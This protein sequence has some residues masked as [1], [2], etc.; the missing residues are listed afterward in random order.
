[1]ML[2]KTTITISKI[3]NQFD[4]LVKVVA[5]GEVTVCEDAAFEE[6][7]LSPEASSDVA[8]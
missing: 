6:L 2:S 8:G 3:I 7:R 4:G 1:M 5:A